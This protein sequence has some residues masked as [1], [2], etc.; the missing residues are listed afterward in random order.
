MQDRST[1]ATD[2]LS[3]DD[4]DDD[5]ENQ[6]E[7]QR[8]SEALASKGGSS[9]RQTMKQGGT[10]VFTRKHDDQEVGQAKL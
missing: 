4:D 3:D 2:K 5:D 1:N 9:T 6:D 10:L 8:L 7:D